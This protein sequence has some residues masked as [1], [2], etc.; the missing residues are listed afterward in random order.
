MKNIVKDL[1]TKV[2]EK[3]QRDFPGLKRAEL[4]FLCSIVF[5]QR[6]WRQRR[7]KNIISEFLSP[8]VPI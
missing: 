4:K 7:I 1:K 8:R 3:Y 5:I 2:Y 6:L